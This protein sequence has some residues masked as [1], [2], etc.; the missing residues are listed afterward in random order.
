MI[1]CIISL[2]L[3]FTPYIVTEHPLYAR[4]CSKCWTLLFDDHHFTDKEMEIQ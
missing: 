1:F 2:T 4:H 3:P